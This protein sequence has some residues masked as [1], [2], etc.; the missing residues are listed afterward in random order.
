[1]FKTIAGWIL[2]AVLGAMAF[3]FW[4]EAKEAE[5][6][7]TELEEFDR[8]TYFSAT[9]LEIERYELTYDYMLEEKESFEWPNAANILDS[10]V[11]FPIDFNE[12]EV[13]SMNKLKSDFLE[14]LVGFDKAL[15]DDERNEYAE[16]YR[17]K[18]D[19]YKA[20]F[21]SLAEEY[22]YCAYVTNEFECQGN[23]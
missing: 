2:A 23:L 3:V 9:Y 13:V 22:G 12:K 20:H 17:Q 6:N 19:E 10:F 14:S 1:M 16:S 8:S 7:I 4:A 21:N 18:L 15:T 11:K 5:M